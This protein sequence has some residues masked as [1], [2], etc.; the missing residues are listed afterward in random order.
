MFCPFLCFWLN[1]RRKKIRSDECMRER[2]NHG[3]CTCISKTIVTAGF[4]GVNLSDSLDKLL[5]KA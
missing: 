1:G 5:L 3:V 4:I 2:E